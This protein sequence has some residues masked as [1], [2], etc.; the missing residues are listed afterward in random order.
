[1]GR[2][3]TLRFWF[4]GIESN[5]ESLKQGFVSHISGATGQ[6]GLNMA[7]QEDAVLAQKIAEMQKQFKVANISAA[8]EKRYGVTVDDGPR[9]VINQCSC[10]I[11]TKH[12]GYRGVGCRQNWNPI[13]VV[14]RIARQDVHGAMLEQPL[15]AAAGCLSPES[16]HGGGGYLHKTAFLGPFQ[17]P[18]EILLQDRISLRVSQH[19]S[20]ANGKKAREELVDLE[21][22]GVVTCLPMMGARRVPEMADISS[23]S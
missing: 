12:F 23:Q 10:D 6:A 9:I 16:S 4:D 17:N 11:Q 20:K 18:P 3:D 2:R 15:R 8:R 13:L 22:Y 14:M 5:V 7:V 1:M 21:R 19:G